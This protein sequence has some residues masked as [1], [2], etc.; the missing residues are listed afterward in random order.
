MIQLAVLAV[1]VSVRVDLPVL[2]PQEMQ[3]DVAFLQLFANFFPVRERFDRQ[4]GC[5]NLLWKEQ[6]V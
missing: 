3:G 4:V 2:L 1:A 6:P 5:L